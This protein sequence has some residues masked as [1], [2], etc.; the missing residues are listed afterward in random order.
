MR[1]AVAVLILALAQPALADDASPP[2]HS[3]KPAGVKR[4]PR[5]KAGKRPPRGARVAPA[6]AEPSSPRTAV[7]PPQEPSD[8]DALT[9]RLVGATHAEGEYGGVVPGHPT[10]S[11]AH[12]ARRPPPKGTLSWIG[13][14]AKD[15]GAQVFFQS[16]GPFEVSQGVEGGVLVAHL[17]GLRGLAGNT[18]RAVD[19]RF[20]DN[21]LALIVARRVS[22]AAARKGAAGHPA[23]IEVRLTFKN[24]KDAHPATVRTATEADG[25]FYAYLDL[26]EG[27]EPAAPAE[28]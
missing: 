16:P 24:A 28:P 12:K 25:L 22:A 19:T 20:F 11:T 8:G 10:P 15:G 2:V 6:E 1:R 5:P 3:G 7:P 17:T 23:G 26:A 13:F 14:A 18:Q 4:P 9:P 27:A 21:P